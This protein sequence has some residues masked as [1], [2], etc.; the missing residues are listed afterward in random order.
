MSTRPDEELAI[1]RDRAQRVTNGSS[2]SL[3]TAHLQHSDSEK[4]KPKPGHSL[5]SVPKAAWARFNGYGR[6]RIGLFQ[7]VKAV[8]F[9]SCTFTPSSLALL[10]IH[11]GS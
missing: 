6:K 10:G 7:S 5:T 11:L 1:A 8:L 9:S 3:P 4:A 2:N